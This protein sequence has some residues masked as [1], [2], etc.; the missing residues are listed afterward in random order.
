MTCMKAQ[1]L[2]T[3]FI[4]DKL[5]IGELE[6]FIRHIRSCDGC[7]E[8]L[9]VYYALLTAMNQLDE[10][11]NLS[12]DFNQELREKLDH[13]E[14]RI[15]HLRFN[16]YRKKGALLVIIIFLGVFFSI[17]H[18]FGPVEEKNT[19]IESRFRLRISF[20]EE[21]FDKPTEELANYLNR[22]QNN[23]VIE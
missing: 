20:M 22:E 8:E 14:E 11:K 18:Y 10:D 17:K 3:A 23:T 9:E 12:D 16:Y 21:R 4:Y 19:V 2:I 5:D 1:G 15:I 13:A 6:E 7:R